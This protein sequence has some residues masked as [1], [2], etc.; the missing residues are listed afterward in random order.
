MNKKRQVAPGSVQNPL[1][2]VDDEGMERE[3]IS[4]GD[5]ITQ[6]FD[7]TL[8]RV[9][10][11]PFTVD[12]LLSRIK[13]KEIDLSPAFQRR[14]GIWSDTAQSRLIESLLIRI[15]LPAFYMDATDDD[16]WVVVDGLQRLSTLRRF[17]LEQGLALRDLEFVSLL[18]GKTYDQLPRSFQR[19]ILETTLTL[20]L[21]QSGT[22]PEVKFNIFKRINTGG[23]PLSAQEIRHALNQG[24]VTE[25]LEDLA[26]SRE[27]KR[28]TAGG[29][30]PKRMGDRECVLRYLAFTLTDPED[31]RDSDFD[32]FLNG[33]MVQVNRFSDLELK[34][35]DLGFKRALHIAHECFG[36]YAFR[37]RYSMDAEHRS[38][39]NKA[40]FESWTVNLGRLKED[41]ANQLVKRKDDLERES[42]RLMKDRAFEE[43]VSQGTG[44]IRKVRLRFGRISD[45]LEKVL[46]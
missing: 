24:K 16:R 41:E 14:D 3:T 33:C 39:I 40:L 9:E 10:P 45:L 27:F 12:L 15:P 8:I 36:K 37:K 26:Q 42:C 31:Y 43:A 2:D 6:P 35:L 22:P 4:S 17:V 23:L 32:A 20:F 13:K 34:K 7:P 44:D 28:A 5:S 11:R 46:T 18:E 19:R 1:I 21:I 38:P 30:S 25:F 29:I